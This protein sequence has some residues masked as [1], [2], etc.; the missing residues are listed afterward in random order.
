M[1]TE[2]ETNPADFRHQVALQQPNDTPDGIGGQTRTWT[3]VATVWGRVTPVSGSEHPD[4]MGM[5]QE[6]SFI[7]RI[8]YRQM[9][10]STDWRL[11]FPDGTLGNISY[12]EDINLAHWYLDIHYRVGQ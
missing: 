11:L 6:A 8:R 2:L 3:T 4:A 1:A 9:L 12:I 5:R 7:L 10:P